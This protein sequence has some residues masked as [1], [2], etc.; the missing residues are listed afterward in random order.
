MYEDIWFGG[1][2]GLF[3][4]GVVIC[5]LSIMMFFFFGYEVIE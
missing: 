3:G 5:M 1:V 4:G 2:F